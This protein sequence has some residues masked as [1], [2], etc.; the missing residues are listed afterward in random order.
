M[1]QTRPFALLVQNFPVA[2]VSKWGRERPVV[3][4]SSLYRKERPEGRNPINT[5]Y[6]TGKEAGEDISVE[7]NYLDI[8]Q[9]VLLSSKLVDEVIN[10]TC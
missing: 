1:R 3:Y 7:I 8:L 4:F 2:K 9:E 5:G 6:K 10:Y